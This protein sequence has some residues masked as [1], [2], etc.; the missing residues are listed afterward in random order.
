MIAGWRTIPVLALSGAAT[1]SLAY[2][3]Q[4]G[5]GS[6]FEFPLLRL[7]VGLILCTLVAVITVLAVR[8][9]KRT[10]AFAPSG[11]G[12]DFLRP[13]PL[14]LRV[15]ESQRLSPH[16]D[17]CVFTCDSREYLVVVSAAGATVLREQTCD[18]KAPP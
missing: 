3:Q 4:L 9:F 17:A 1:P 5:G 11:R 14:R 13:P 7:A 16:A 10:G 6:H 2:A 12:F 8:R 18:D 15:V